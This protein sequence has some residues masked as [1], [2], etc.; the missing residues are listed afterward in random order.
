MEQTCFMPFSFLRVQLIVRLVA[1][2]GVAISCVA[3]AAETTTQN[4][5][6]SLPPK[7]VEKPAEKPVEKTVSVTRVV[8]EVGPRVVTSR[9]VRINE[10]VGQVVAGL[11]NAGGP[12]KVLSATDA[13]FPAGV[14]KVLD[15]WTVF[16]E[17]SEIGAKMADKA[18][19]AKWAKQVAD[20]WKGV[21]DW[22]KL[23]ASAAEVREAVERK[24][25][26]QAFERLKG[27]ASLVT[28]S[29]ADALLY[30]KKNRLRFGNLPFENFKDNIKAA[31]VRGQTER[32][33][34]EWRAVLR[35]KYRVRNFVGA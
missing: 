22:E 25:A 29:D 4:T 3:L 6:P 27:D 10:A 2:F 13:G 9:E 20:N 5:T 24:L 35:R 26:A 1:T 12:R 23:E 19:V 34:Y 14:L 32:R 21:G 16:L 31:L 17:A 11:P 30:Y 18:E 15:E 7:A 33:L 28:V 8:G